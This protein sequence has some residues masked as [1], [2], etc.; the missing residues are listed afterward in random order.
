MVETAYALVHQTC[1]NG[2]FGMGAVVGLT[3]E[4]IGPL[5]EKPEFAS[6]EL[7]NANNATSLVLSGAKRELRDLLHEAEALGAFKAVLLNIDRPYHNPRFL[8]PVTHTFRHFLKG[9]AWH[10]PRHPIVS[11][12]DQRLLSTPEDLLDFTARNLAVP[13]HW[14]KVIETFSALGVNLV[15]ECGPGLS[16]TQNARFIPGSP[17]HVNTKTSRRRLGV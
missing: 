16:L 2:D 14:H 4:D 17:P 13:I 5:L 1:P 7:A 9:L 12:L 11:S 15:I 3:T 8:E 6:I 10:T